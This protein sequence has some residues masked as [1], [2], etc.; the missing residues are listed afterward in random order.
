MLELDWCLGVKT[1]ES[2][3]VWF[4]TWWIVKFIWSKDYGVC[5]KMKMDYWFYKRYSCLVVGI[6]LMDNLDVGFQIGFRVDG[7]ASIITK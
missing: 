3:G 1:M 5:W 2:V 6:G 7:L 4:Q